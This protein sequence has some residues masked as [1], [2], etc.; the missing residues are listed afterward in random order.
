MP[1]RYKVDV[2]KALKEKGVT[3]YLLRKNQILSE[4]TIQKLRKGIGVSWDNIETLCRL[5]QC[6][7][8]EIIE[9]VPDETDEIK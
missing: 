7:P 2:I 6:Q 3:T 5:L 4:S 8:S 9:Y 1:L